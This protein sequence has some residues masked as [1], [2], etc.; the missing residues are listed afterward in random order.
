MNKEKYAWAGFG[1]P[2]AWLAELDHIPAANALADAFG[3]SYL[4]RYCPVFGCVRDAV[5]RLGYSFCAADTPLWR[6]Y[7]SFPLMSLPRILADRTIPYVDNGVTFRRLIREYPAVRLPPG[8]ITGNMKANHAFHESAHCVAHAILQKLRLHMAHAESCGAADAVFAESFANTVEAL[9][10]GF[11]HMPVSDHVFYPL[12]SYI[13]QNDKIRDVLVR[14]AALGSERRFTVLF[15]SYFEANLT[16]EPASDKSC[17]Q[18]AETAGCASEQH[19]LARE[20]MEVAF[21]LKAGFRE[22]T[23]PAYFDLLGLGAEYRALAD[24]NWLA[25]RENQSLAREVATLYWEAAGKP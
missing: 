12:N 10:S 14:A 22:T 25:K 5:L 23:T 11:S 8:F 21:G 17:G 1:V 4:Y 2:L 24:G 6:D 7:Q 13:P 9:G 15:L 16:A 18:V 3:D 20:I 19:G